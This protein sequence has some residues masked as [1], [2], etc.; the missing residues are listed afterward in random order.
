MVIDQLGRG[1]LMLV[2]TESDD[3]PD[4]IMAGWA[5]Q[6]AWLTAIDDGLVASVLGGVLDAPGVRSALACRLRL[7]GCPQLLLRVGWAGRGATTA[8]RAGC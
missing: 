7:N 1:A 2:S 5:V 3:A 8:I 4:W 6:N